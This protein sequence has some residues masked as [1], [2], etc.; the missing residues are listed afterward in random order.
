MPLPL[1]FAALDHEAR[2]HAVEGEVV[3]ETFVD[4]VLDLCDGVRRE[5]LE[6]LE[7][8]VAVDAVGRVGDGELK[9]GFPVGTVVVNCGPIRQSWSTSSCSPTPYS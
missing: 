4:Q 3:V 5:V 6:Q 7:G 9:L 2:D 1:G 8:H